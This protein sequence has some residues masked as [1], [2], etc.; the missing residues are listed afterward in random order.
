MAGNIRRLQTSLRLGTYWL[1]HSLLE[2]LPPNKPWKRSDTGY[3][4][5]KAN[6]RI[7]DLGLYRPSL[8]MRH[9]NGFLLWK[10][11]AS[12]CVGALRAFHTP[13]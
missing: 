1:C 11:I 2:T 9:Q 12:T 10:M 13:V 5:V 8:E 6:I 7:V 4:S 3:M